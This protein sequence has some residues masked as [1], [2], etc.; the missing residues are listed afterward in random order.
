MKMHIALT[1]LAAGA[2]AFHTSTALAQVLTTAPNVNANVNGGFG[3]AQ[4]LTSTVGSGALGS[5]SQQLYMAS[6]FGNLAP[7]GN[8]ITE[9]RFRPIEA[10]FIF[11]GN[12][13]TATNLTITLSTTQ[14]TDAGANQLSTTFDSNVGGN[15]Q[16][17]YSGALTLMTQATTLPNGTFAFDYIITLQNAFNYNPAQ[18]NLLLDI[19]VPA[20]N[21]VRGNSPFGGFAR[22][23][24]TNPVG[25]DGTASVFTNGPGI[26]ATGIYTLGGAV[27]QFVS[28]PI[29]AP[30][31]AALLAMGGV[32]IARRRRQ[33]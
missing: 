24:T 2:V 1:C 17:V 30:G 14:R 4:P 7:L 31:A 6:Q 18:G 20:G 5:R 33:R 9:I 28:T 11:A 22:F 12:T 32:G 10:P 27:T 29:P 15:A 26:T 3:G 13:I 16:V 19:V 23:D 21:T 8:S 25:P